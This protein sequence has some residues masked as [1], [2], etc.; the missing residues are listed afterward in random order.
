MLHNLGAGPFF[1]TGSSC[2]DTSGVEMEQLAREIL[3]ALAY[4]VEDALRPCV[5]SAVDAPLPQARSCIGDVLIANSRPLSALLCDK[6]QSMLVTETR[7]LDAISASD[8]PVSCRLGQTT[9]SVW[10]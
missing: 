4:E 10:R 8:L 7:S 1:G 3:A 2:F 5:L 6:V 9:I